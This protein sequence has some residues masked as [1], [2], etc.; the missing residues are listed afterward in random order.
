MQNFMSNLPHLIMA[1][2]VIAAASALAATGTITGAEALLIIGS[3]GGFSLGAGAGSASGPP[4]A[5]TVSAT[6][7]SS[8]ESTVTVAPAAVTVAHPGTPALVNGPTPTTTPA[9]P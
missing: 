6:T 5:P 9:S 8:G 4:S 7:S 2:V 1:T 3:A